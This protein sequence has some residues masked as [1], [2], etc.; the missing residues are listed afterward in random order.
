MTH[1]HF[2]NPEMCRNNN[3]MVYG[4]WTL[5]S[6]IG[7]PG[8]AA[9]WALPRVARPVGAGWACGPTRQPAKG[10][11]RGRPNGEGPGQLLWGFPGPTPRRLGRLGHTHRCQS[12]G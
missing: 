4:P 1:M 8:P 9:R 11:G 5:P 10:R 2:P 12:Q 6:L 7:G 3:I